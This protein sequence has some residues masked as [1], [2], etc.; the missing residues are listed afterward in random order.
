MFWMAWGMLLL[1]EDIWFVGELVFCCFGR[2]SKSVT[3]GI[4]IVGPFLVLI[5]DTLGG[6]ANLLVLA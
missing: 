1:F 5:L 2:V 4:T 3:G 6:Q